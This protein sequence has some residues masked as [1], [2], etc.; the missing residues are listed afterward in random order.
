MDELNYILALL[1]KAHGLIDERGE[2]SCVLDGLSVA[3]DIVKAAAS[4]QEVDVEKIV[5]EAFG[6]GL[7]DP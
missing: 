7:S 5:E 4:G 2:D 3:A 1:Q 6:D